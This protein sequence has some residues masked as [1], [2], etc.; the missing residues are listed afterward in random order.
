[1]EN[2]INPHIGL[3]SWEELR[4]NFGARTHAPIRTGNPIADDVLTRVVYWRGGPQNLQKLVGKFINCAAEKRWNE[5]QFS[6][7]ELN[8]LKW[9]VGQWIAGMWEQPLRWDEKLDDIKTAEGLSV[10][11]LK[12][13]LPHRI[14]PL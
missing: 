4:R 7:Y 5:T 12:E 1:M 13:C 14:D 2:A 6:I 9:Y 8:L 11:I 3:L 10:F